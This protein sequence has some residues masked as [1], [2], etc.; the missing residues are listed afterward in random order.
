MHQDIALRF[1]TAPPLHNSG[2]KSALEKIAFKMSEP[3]P[4]NPVTVMWCGGLKSDMEGGKATY[5]HDWAIARGFGFI[6]FD[7]FGH[8]QSSGAF[9]DGTISRWARDT[10]QIMDELA[11]TDI[12]LVGSSM[13]G[14]ASLLAMM[15]RADRVKAM[16]LIA[17]APDFTEKLMWAGWSP[18][19][20]A[21]LEAKGILYEPSDYDE[22]YEYSRELI[23]DGRARQILDNPITFDGPVQILQG[24]QDNVVPPEY[25]MKLIDVMTSE[26][27][28]YTLV[29]SGD[30]SLSTPRD[31]ERLGQALE[32]LVEKVLPGQ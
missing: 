13:G 2:P 12:I 11:K 29:K 22:P 28:D 5:L 14:W 18:E 15:E 3:Q 9:R 31:L 26:D 32:A 10:V 4:G 25:S 17:P 21:E 8:G 20:R 16:L 7:Y 23:E 27:I 6:R 30:H 1:L 19:Q 24:A